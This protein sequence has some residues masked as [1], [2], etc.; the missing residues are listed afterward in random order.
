M[1]VGKYSPTVSFAYMKD[2]DW[3]DKN[4]TNGDV[5]YDDD[6]YDR[7]GYDR[8]DR[9]RAGVYENDYMM[10]GRWEGEDYVY[11]LYEEISGDWSGRLCAGVKFGDEMKKESRP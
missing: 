1:G 2:Q 5:N 8:D 9:D 10:N 3:W 4:N 11:P 7:Y 6:G